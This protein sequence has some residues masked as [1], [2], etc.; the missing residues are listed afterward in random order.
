[1]IQG[2]AVVTYAGNALVA[3]LPCRLT[4]ATPS[5]LLVAYSARK[6]PW[7]TQALLTPQAPQLNVVP[8]SAAV[9]PQ[10]GTLFD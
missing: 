7:R 3:F 8:P 6:C 9:E 4:R 10:Q 1:M 2:P 5:T